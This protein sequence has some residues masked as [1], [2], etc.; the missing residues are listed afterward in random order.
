MPEYSQIHN[1][2]AT[3]ISLP[4]RVASSPKQL[5]HLK[6]F[7]VSSQES[8]NALSFGLAAFGLLVLVLLMM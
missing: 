7:W 2:T 4:M 8:S 1:L 6:R 5:I 3:S